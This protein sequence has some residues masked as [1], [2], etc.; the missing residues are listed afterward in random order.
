M[1]ELISG[2]LRSYAEPPGIPNEQDVLARLFAERGRGQAKR[3]AGRRKLWPW[4]T[5]ACACAAMLLMAALWM[6]RA[7]GTQEIAWMPG[8]PGVAAVANPAPEKPIAGVARAVHTSAAPTRLPK[9]DIFPAPTPQ[10]PEERALA[11]FSARASATEK[12]KVLAAQE[13]LDDPIRIA[14]LTIRPLDVDEMKDQS[15]GKDLR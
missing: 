12:Q 14:E 4:A 6:L 2:A 5:A 7:P 3:E 8:A 11:T 9:L 13:H 1:D 15:T 10:S